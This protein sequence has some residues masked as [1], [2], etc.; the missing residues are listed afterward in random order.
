[1]HYLNAV[2]Q[3]RNQAFPNESIETLRLEILQ[4]FMIG[5][6]DEILAGVRQLPLCQRTTSE[7]SNYGG[8]FQVRS[9]KKILNAS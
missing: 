2:K 9:S 4:R 5:V 7:Q 3:I 1:M 8:S 6:R